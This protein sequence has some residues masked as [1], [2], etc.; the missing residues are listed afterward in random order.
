[1]EYLY[2]AST[3][4]GRQDG[5]VILQR[6]LWQ[7]VTDKGKYECWN[8]VGWGSA[9][10]PILS[11][12]IGELSFKRVG[13]GTWVVAYLNSTSGHIVTRTASYPYGP[14]SSEKIQLADATSRQE[15]TP[16]ID[17][18]STKNNLRFT[19]SQF[20]DTRYGITIHHGNH[21]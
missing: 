9:C 10:E 7:Q 19:V 18:R 4:A 2:M 12:N 15:Y 17:P 1:G 16:S 11:G 13:D 8:G 14:W 20:N 3:P 6:V 5:L 21:E